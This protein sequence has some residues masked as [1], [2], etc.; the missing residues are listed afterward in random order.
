LLRL[1]PV[2]LLE[3]GLTYWTHAF[4]VRIEILKDMFNDVVEEPSGTVRRKEVG[5]FLTLA[6][7]H[8]FIPQ[9]V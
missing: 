6:V 5:L 2:S 3:G 7:V 8:N 4:T 9:A 1:Y